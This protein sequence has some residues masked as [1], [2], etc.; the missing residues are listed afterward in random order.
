M[1]LVKVYKT[2]TNQEITGTSLGQ[3]VYPYKKTNTVIRKLYERMRHLP[4]QYKDGY[5]YRIYQGATNETDGQIVVTL[6]IQ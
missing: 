2:G 5:H 1:Y 3:G 4:Q 6:Q